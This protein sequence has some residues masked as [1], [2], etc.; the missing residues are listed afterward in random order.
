MPLPGLLFDDIRQASHVLT[1]QVCERD[2]TKLKGRVD[3]VGGL[4]QVPELRVVNCEEKR[5]ELRRRRLRFAVY[6]R[7]RY[8]RRNLGDGKVINGF[9]SRHVS[10]CFFE[11]LQHNVQYRGMLKIQTSADSV[12]RCRKTYLKART[13]PLLHIRRVPLV[14]RIRIAVR[15]IQKDMSPR[16][17]RRARPVRPRKRHQRFVYG[18]GLAD[19][20]F[21]RLAE[22]VAEISRPLRRRDEGKKG[23]EVSTRMHS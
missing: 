18:L 21:R 17:T 3:A 19:G 22:D 5:A 15:E 9:L 10:A 7:D 12:R 1:L 14:F 6:P 16:F 4:G 11:L 2:T 20:H 23:K 13:Y 8:G